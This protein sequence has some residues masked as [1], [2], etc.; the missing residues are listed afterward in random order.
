MMSKNKLPQ[1]ECQSIN[2]IRQAAVSREFSNNTG[3]KA[4]VMISPFPF[5]VIGKIV[6]VVEDFVFFD[7][8]TTHISELEGKVLRIHLDDIEVFYIENGGPKIPVISNNSVC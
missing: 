7:V 3:N 4:L 5:M 6:K 2:A 8:K 1:C